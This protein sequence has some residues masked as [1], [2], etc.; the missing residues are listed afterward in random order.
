[1]LLLNPIGTPWRMP[2]AADHVVFHFRRSLCSAPL[3]ELPVSDFN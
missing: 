2:I 3:N 1:M